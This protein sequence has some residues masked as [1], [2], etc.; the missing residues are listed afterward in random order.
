MVLGIWLPFRPVVVFIFQA[1]LLLLNNHIAAVG[2]LSE[3][4]ST[5]LVI[6]E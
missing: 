4:E 2:S 6:S 1:V 3:A 5:L